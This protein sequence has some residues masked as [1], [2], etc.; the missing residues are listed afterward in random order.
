[1]QGHI[2]FGA[3]HMHPALPAYSSTSLVPTSHRHEYPPAVALAVAAALVAAGPLLLFAVAVVVAV[4][5]LSSADPGVHGTHAAP[6]NCCEGV[7]EGQRAG[8]TTMQ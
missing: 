6:G 4:A 5:V 7:A 1:M 8:S 3:H 2:A